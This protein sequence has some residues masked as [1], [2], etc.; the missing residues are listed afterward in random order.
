MLG[1]TEAEGVAARLRDSSLRSPDDLTVHDI[2]YRDIAG[3]DQLTGGG[4]PKGRATLVCG[5]PGCGKTLFAMEFLIR[6]AESRGKPAGV[7]HAVRGSVDREAPGGARELSRGARGRIDQLPVH[8]GGGSQPVDLHH[9]VFPL[10]AITSGMRMPV[11]AAF[12]VCFACP[13]RPPRMITFGLTRTN[14]A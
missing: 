5:G 9:V 7:R 12:S 8:V 4:L 10:D 3:F 14:V 6:G 13:P 11:L 2:D 1:A